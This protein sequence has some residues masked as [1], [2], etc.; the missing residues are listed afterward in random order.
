MA[1]LEKVTISCFLDMTGKSEELPLILEGGL[2]I[3]GTRI[4]SK[5]Y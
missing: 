3:L 4:C 5:G 2:G 1:V